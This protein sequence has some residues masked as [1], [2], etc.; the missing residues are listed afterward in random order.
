[1]F[2]DTRKDGN[3]PN[4]GLKYLLAIQSTVSRKKLSKRGSEDKNSTMRP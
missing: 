1:M 4:N 3:S 2:D